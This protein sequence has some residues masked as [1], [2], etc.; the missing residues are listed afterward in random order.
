MNNLLSLA[1]QLT[2][3]SEGNLLEKQVE[4]CKTIHASGNDLLTLINDIL[5]LSK[6]ESG[7]VTLDIAELRFSELQDYCERTFRHVAESKTLDFTIDLDPQL[8]RQ[9]FTDSQ[10]LEQVI[11]NLLSNAFKFTER[12]RVVF[13]MAVATEGWSR[14]RET[15]NHARSVVAF[16]VTDTGIG[17]APEKQAIIFEA[18]Q[19]ADG[20]TSRRYG[21]TGL[22]LAISREIARL[23]GGE[24]RLA[25]AVGQ[26]S[27]FTLY[28]PQAYVAPKPATR[29]TQ[30]TLTQQQQQAETK[31]LLAPAEE[32]EQGDV[33]IELPAIADVV[34]DSGSIG[35]D[36]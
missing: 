36:D 29:P 8:P 1:Q 24:I 12:G 15:L 2:L 16:S 18:F 4:F 28:L 17:I 32:D 22:G 5:D 26:G 20:S 23:L 34:D 21:G 7:T 35:T 9:I 3:N 6:I 14:D 33:S 19:Q 27:T 25:S 11:R 30:Q 31:A 13:S 10:R